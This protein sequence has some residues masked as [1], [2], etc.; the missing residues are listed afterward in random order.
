[1]GG[2]VKR[3]IVSMII[4][5]SLSAMA[6]VSA[7][8]QSKCAQAGSFAKD[9]H[10]TR[11]HGLP[12]D[13]VIH[14]AD[15]AKG[16]ADL[17]QFWRSNIHAVYQLPSKASGAEVSEGFYDGSMKQIAGRW[18]AMGKHTWNSA[19]EDLMPKDVNLSA[20]PLVSFASFSVKILWKRRLRHSSRKQWQKRYCWCVTNKTMM[21]SN[22]VNAKNI[23]I[24]LALESYRNVYLCNASRIAISWR[25]NYRVIL[26]FL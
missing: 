25:C 22:R 3:S 21:T 9:I 4:G 5:I 26:C 10:T 7:P 24:W 15:Q 17:H 13:R 19:V 12:A 2:A 1:M 11:A 16:S 18:I 6:G 23:F 14:Q 20:N 8:V